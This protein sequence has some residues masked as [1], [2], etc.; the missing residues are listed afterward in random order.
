MGLGE[1]SRESVEAC[2][3]GG[4]RAVPPRNHASPVLPVSG[5]GVYSADAF[6]PP[7]FWAAGLYQADARGFAEMF[8][9]CCATVREFARSESLPAVVLYAVGTPGRPGPKDWRTEMRPGCLSPQT[10][11]LQRFRNAVNVSK[12]LMLQARRTTVEEQNLWWAGGS[13]S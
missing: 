12:I 13:A 6:R 5:G 11:L 7:A 2:T 3:M 1:I 9:H 4:G 8:L 10:D